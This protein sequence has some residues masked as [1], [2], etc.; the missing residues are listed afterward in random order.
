M[1]IAS[2]D[3]FWVL[4]GVG[5]RCAAVLCS[6]FPVAGEG[7]LDVDRD[8]DIW[9]IKNII[10]QERTIHPTDL[11][12][13]ARLSSASCGPA[14]HSP[15]GP[16][17]EAVQPSSSVLLYFRLSNDLQGISTKRLILEKMMGEG[18]WSDSE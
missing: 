13:S 18:E 6:M 15:L 16:G 3:L 10:H 7:V 9:R 1:S 8:L 14:V 4:E 12:L 11:F 2:T 17:S 5:K